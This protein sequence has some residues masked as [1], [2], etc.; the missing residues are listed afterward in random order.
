MKLYQNLSTGA[1]WT[2]EE[3]EH[4][5]NLLYEVHEDF[6]TFEQYLE[7]L[8]TTAGLLEISVGDVISDGDGLYKIENIEDETVSIAQYESEELD[9]HLL[10]RAYNIT[11]EEL[12]DL[13]VIC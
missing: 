12:A 1:I 4:E 5:Y 9:D 3:V 8:L 6:P 13:F 10:G 11:T 2:W 7:H